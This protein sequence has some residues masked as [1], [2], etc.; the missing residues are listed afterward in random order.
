MRS[1]PPIV[2]GT[3]GIPERETVFAARGA[4]RLTSK[5]VCPCEFEVEVVDGELSGVVLVAAD[6]QLPELLGPSRNAVQLELGGLRFRCLTDGYL[7]DSD[8]LLLRGDSFF[9][10]LSEA[11]LARSQQ[12]LRRPQKRSGHT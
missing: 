11:L 12:N 4:L 10:G 6:D 1:L 9:A 5:Q 8:T 7:E 2:A 3:I